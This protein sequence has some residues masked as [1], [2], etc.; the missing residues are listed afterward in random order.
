MDAAAR[1]QRVSLL[2]GAGQGG[3]ASGFRVA[4]WRRRWAEELGLSKG[5]VVQGEG[6]QELSSCHSQPLAC[7]SLLGR[8]RLFSTQILAQ[9]TLAP[10]SAF[11]GQTRAETWQM[12]C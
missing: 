6:A 1:G 3:C 7:Q 5:P 12:R 2:R 4:S 9:L 10:A 11:L 8:R